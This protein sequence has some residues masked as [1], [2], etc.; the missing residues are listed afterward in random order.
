MTPAELD[1]ALAQMSQSDTE[2]RQ[3]LAPV[4]TAQWHWKPDEESWSLCQIA[5]HLVIVEQGVMFRL[6][7]APAD[8]I[9]KTVGKQHLPAMLVDRRERFP[10][11]ARTLPSGTKFESPE[12]YLAQLATARTNTLGWAQDADTK[13]MEHVMP[14]PAFGDLHGGQWLQMLAGHTL[15]HLAQMRELMAL[16]GY[17]A[18]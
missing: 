8:G 2:L 13:L 17:P 14:H 16:P 5:E 15:R 6:R 4:T 3:L 18:E 11:P 1:L 9:E 7:T 10:A 12:E